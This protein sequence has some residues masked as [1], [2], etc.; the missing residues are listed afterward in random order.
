[1]KEELKKSAAQQ[2]KVRKSLKR[3]ERVLEKQL[4]AL[5]VARA[6][7]AKEKAAKELADMVRKDEILIKQQLAEVRKKERALNLAL[8]ADKMVG[9]KGAAR[10]DCAAGLPWS[11]T[12]ATDPPAATVTGTLLGLSQRFGLSPADRGKLKLPPSTTAA[13]ASSTRRL[14]MPSLEK[15]MCCQPTSISAGRR[16]SLSVVPAASALA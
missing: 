6:G 5:T 13:A 3:K 10:A 11:T 15:A 8:A 9:E 2:A 14:D 12:S 1:M 4:A 16:E 7:A